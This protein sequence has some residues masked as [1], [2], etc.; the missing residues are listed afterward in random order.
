MQTV[1]TIGDF[2]RMTHLSVKTL[3]HYHQVGLL[4]P[5]RIDPTSGYRYYDTTQVPTAQ[6]IRRFRDLDMPVEAVK[7]VLGAPDV[8]ARNALIAAHLNRLEGQLEA[9]R[10]A[11]TSLRN[12]LETPVAAISIEHRSVAATPAL[13]ISETVSV[14]ELGSWWFGAISEIHAVL[15]SRRVDPSGPV[16]GLYANELFLDERGD[17]VVFVPVAAPTPGSGRAQSLIIPAVELAIALHEGSHDDI[18]QS[19]GPLGTYVIEHA[20]G[21]EGPVRESYLVGAFDTDDTD[22][23][24]TEIGWPV[25]Q[26]AT[27]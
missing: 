17:A 13:A 4:E 16:G 27:G 2:S 11:V 10:A 8:G 6:V 21:V 23:W 19:Y 22:Q 20:L 9:T 15:R 12:L 14:D 26:T 18:D 3:R 25:F 24:R 5:V 7:A 1:L